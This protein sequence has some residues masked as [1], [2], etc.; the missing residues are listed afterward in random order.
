MRAL[1]HRRLLLLLS[2]EHATLHLRLP[3]RLRLVRG[4][5]LQRDGLHAGGPGPAPVLH[6]RGD[7]QRGEH[8]DVSGCR[9]DESGFRHSGEW[10]DCFCG[11]D[12]DDDE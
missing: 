1:H 10:E 7:D 3:L 2:P 6:P 9:G 5:N 8:G 12:D 4:R 11:D